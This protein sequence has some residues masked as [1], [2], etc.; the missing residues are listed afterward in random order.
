MDRRKMKRLISILMESP[1]YMTMSV[2]ECHSLL[3]RMDHD[4]PLD[5]EG[6]D[7]GYEASWNGITQFRKAGD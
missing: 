6:A 3:S 2:K 1:L 7:V 4:Y 5:E